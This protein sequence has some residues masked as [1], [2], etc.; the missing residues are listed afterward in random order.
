[1]KEHP[2]CEPGCPEAVNSSNDNDADCDE[3][4]EGKRI[5][6]ATST[7]KIYFSFVIFHLS[8]GHF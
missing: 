5:Y 4:F 2:D 1:V 7:K 8:I 6:D 3:Q